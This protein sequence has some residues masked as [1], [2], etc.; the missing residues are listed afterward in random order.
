MIRPGNSTTYWI[1]R[2]VP[3][4]WEEVQVP[5]ARYRALHY[6]VLGK[7]DRQP[8]SGM[9]LFFTEFKL[10]VWYAP[11]IRRIVKLEHQLWTSNPV[12]YAD[13]EVELMEYRPPR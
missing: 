9:S 11:E 12:P 4:E 1:I 6:E 13:D 5:A 2:V 10:N 3:H 8:V 7:K